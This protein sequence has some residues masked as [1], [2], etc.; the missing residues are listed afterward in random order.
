METITVT[1]QQDNKWGWGFST[2][3]EQTETGLSVVA[4]KSPDYTGTLKRIGRAIAKD[5]LF[6]SLTF[7]SKATRWFY[8]GRPII[9]Q[10]WFFKNNDKGHFGMTRDMQGFDPVERMLSDGEV[11][12]GV[13]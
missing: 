7:T 11:T 3:V 2:D 8:D 4:P 10:E 6:Q 5:R 9:A 12:F 13:E 1:N